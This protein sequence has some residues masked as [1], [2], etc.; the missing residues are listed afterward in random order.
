M[1]AN[2][3][4]GKRD[5]PRPGRHLVAV[6][7]NHHQHR[8]RRAR[9][10]RAPTTP[11]LS[12]SMSSKSFFGTPAE[13]TANA[14]NQRPQRQGSRLPLRDGTQ[15]ARPRHDLQ[16]ACEIGSNTSS[17]S[18][19]GHP[20]STGKIPHGVGTLD[21][22]AE[23]SDTSSATLGLRHGGG[24]S[25][26]CKSN[27][28]SI[29]NYNNQFLTPAQ[30]VLDYSRRCAPLTGR[31]STRIRAWHI[32]GPPQHRVWHGSPARATNVVLVPSGAAID[33]DKSGT[34]GRQRDSLTTGPPAGARWRRRG[35]C[36]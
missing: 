20:G 33:W 30:R 19:G 25:L 12:T 31:T 26:N 14:S 16:P 32:H 15:P 11:P 28:V 5:S 18:P 8:V 21:Q 24:D 22:P 10:P 27:Y 36:P 23:P 7:K 34:L 17:F 4:S 6:G 13:R 9:R 2:A 1:F 29:M 3:P 35:R